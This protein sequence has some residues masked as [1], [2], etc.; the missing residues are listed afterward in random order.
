YFYLFFFSSAPA[1]S[2]IY[3]SGSVEI[4]NLT[5]TNDLNDPTSQKFLL[6]AKAVQ[7]YL[8]EIYEPSF[9][10]KYYLKSVV[11]AFSEGESGLRAYF[12]NTFWAP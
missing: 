8:A 4:P 7:N 1:F 6:Q 10:G 5:Y 9:L 3:I 11:A 12:W 2:F